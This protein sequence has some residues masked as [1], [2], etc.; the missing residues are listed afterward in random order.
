MKR[1][2]TPGTWWRAPD[3]ERLWAYYLCM[4]QCYGMPALE[5]WTYAK[6]HYPGDLIGNI[7]AA[8]NHRGRT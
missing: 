6:E 2:W 8:I 1:E 4:R 3:H 5:A 7:R